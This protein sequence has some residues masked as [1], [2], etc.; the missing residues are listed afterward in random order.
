MSEMQA[1]RSTQPQNEDVVQVRI[2]VVL[3]VPAYCNSTAY[4]EDLRESFLKSYQRENKFK[5]SLQGLGTGT[6][7]LL[8]RVVFSQTCKLRSARD[9]IKSILMKCHGRLDLSSAENQAFSQHLGLTSN[10]NVKKDTEPFAEEFHQ[11]NVVGSS[12]ETNE[13]GALLRFLL[14][15][16][17]LPI[18]CIHRFAHHPDCAESYPG[19]NTNAENAVDRTSSWMCLSMVSGCGSVSHRNPAPCIEIHPH[20]ACTRSRP[21]RE[22]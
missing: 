14:I 8:G 2:Q 6:W 9:R 15:A 21:Q 22:C 4:H 20:L 1:K 5:M 12:G 10:L 16:P 3:P 7:H 11:W 17:S 13:Q 18:K 19:H